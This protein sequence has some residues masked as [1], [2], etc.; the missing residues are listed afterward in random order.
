[1]EALVHCFDGVSLIVLNRFPCRIT[2]LLPNLGHDG[3]A[4]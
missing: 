3:P 2:D 1:M 4:L